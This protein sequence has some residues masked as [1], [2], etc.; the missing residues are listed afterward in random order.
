MTT[1]IV[2]NTCVFVM[3][4]L[5]LAFDDDDDDDD[6]YYDDSYEYDYYITPAKHRMTEM[7]GKA[8]V[9]ARRTA[10]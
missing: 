2:I 5:V 1:I 9:Q 6:H 8:S 10:I 3:I 4:N 7:R